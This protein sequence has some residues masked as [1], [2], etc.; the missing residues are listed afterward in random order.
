VLFSSRGFRIEREDGGLIR[1]VPAE[2]RRYRLVLARPV[3]GGP[4]LAG[5]TAPLEGESP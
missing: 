5:D 4:W 3:P 1:A 2:R